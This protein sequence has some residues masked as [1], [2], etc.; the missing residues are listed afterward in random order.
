MR[1][2]GTKSE[3]VRSEGCWWQEDVERC[4]EKV[5]RVCQRMENTITR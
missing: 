1:S 2:E 4:E 5:M 3:D